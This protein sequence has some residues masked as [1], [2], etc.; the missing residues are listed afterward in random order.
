MMKKRLWRWEVFATCLSYKVS[1][2][3][4]IFLECLLF[5]FTW[6]HCKCVTAIG[7]YIQKW[8]HLNGEYFLK[9]IRILS[10]TYLLNLYIDCSIS[11]RHPVFIIH[12]V[13]KGYIYLCPNIKQ[14][15]GHRRPLCFTL[16][17]LAA[18]NWF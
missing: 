9:F 1:L 17:L 18:T 3:C 10:W 15:I 8:N 14:E 16:V 13:T 11:W 5:P 4:L 2:P 7:V 6:R 12:L